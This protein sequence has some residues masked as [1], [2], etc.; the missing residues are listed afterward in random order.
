MELQRLQ[1]AIHK[2]TLYYTLR[3]YVFLFSIFQAHFELYLSY[4]NS[5]TLIYFIK[6]VH[7]S[8]SRTE[9]FAEQLTHA[10]IT[11]GFVFKPPNAC[12]LILHTETAVIYSRLKKSKQ[13]L[14]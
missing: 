10:A 14:A 6:L 3:F 7:L 9:T 8:L 11:E 12:F 1:K 4:S 2:A 13:P 5:L